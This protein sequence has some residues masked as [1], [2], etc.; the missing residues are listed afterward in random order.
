[1]PLNAPLV[2]LSVMAMRNNAP[3]TA[4]TAEALNISENPPLARLAKAML[5][6]TCIE[7]TPDTRPRTQSGT[8]VWMMV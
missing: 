7:Y 6:P 5:P 8:M 3:P 1:M 4:I 2:T